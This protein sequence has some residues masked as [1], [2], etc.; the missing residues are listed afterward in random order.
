MSGIP[1]REIGAGFPRREPPH[2][3]LS[4]K[5][6]RKAPQCADVSVRQQLSIQ[7]HI[8]SEMRG[9]LLPMHRR[10]PAHT[11]EIPCMRTDCFRLACAR[12]AQRQLRSANKP[13]VCLSTH[14]NKQLADWPSASQ[15]V[16]GHTLC[17]SS[18]RSMLMASK[19]RWG[20]PASRS[21]RSRRCTSRMPYSHGGCLSGRVCGY[22]AF[23]ALCWSV[24]ACSL[25]PARS[26]LGQS[27]RA[28]RAEHDARMF[29]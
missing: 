5:E 23:L 2:A 22:G 29:G 10:S 9:P 12:R 11:R 20:G 8:P 1:L 14:T 15:R 26:S 21:P 24:C 27:L 17:K 6:L 3:Y 4:V 28:C 19:A 18:V 25:I 13:E 7:S 16:S